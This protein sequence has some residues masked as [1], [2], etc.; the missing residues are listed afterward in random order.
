MCKRETA[1]SSQI[2]ASAPFFWHQNTWHI[3]PISHIFSLY[4]LAMLSH[5]VHE[6]GTYWQFLPAV[7]ILPEKMI[8]NKDLLKLHLQMEAFAKILFIKCLGLKK[9]VLSHILQN[10]NWRNIRK[11]LQGFISLSLFTPMNPDFEVIAQKLLKI[12]VVLVFQMRSFIP[13]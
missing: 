1:T 11:Q 13:L 9:C 10:L 12:Y 8:S 4:L 2:A 3:W 5:D 7:Q 6:M